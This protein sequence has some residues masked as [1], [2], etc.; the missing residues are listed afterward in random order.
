MNNRENLI[1][2]KFSDAIECIKMINN[3]LC[4]TLDFIEQ[5][6]HIFNSID[7]IIDGYINDNRIV[8]LLKDY[9][10]YVLGFKCIFYKEKL[11]DDVV[12][13]K[14]L[15]GKI[16][17]ISLYKLFVNTIPFPI[18]KDVIKQQYKDDNFFLN[19]AD[20]LKKNNLTDKEIGNIISTMIKV[21]DKKNAFE[22]SKLLAYFDIPS[23]IDEVKKHPKYC[24]HQ[25]IEFAWNSLRKLNIQFINS[26]VNYKLCAEYYIKVL[27]INEI[28]Q[29]NNENIRDNALELL[30]IGYFDEKSSEMIHFILN[31][32][33]ND[34]KTK[35]SNEQKS[36]I[37]EIMERYN[38]E[39]GISLEK[40][41]YFLTMFLSR[42]HIYDKSENIKRI[43]K[44]SIKAIIRTKLQEVGIKKCGI[45]F[46]KIDNGLLGRCNEY[47]QIPEIWINEYLISG[48]WLVAISRI[49]LLET[50]FHEMN[51][52]LVANNIK[53]K[54]I[55]F[56]TFLLL[57]DKFIDDMDYKYYDNNYDI[58]REEFD[59]NL[60]GLIET[61]RFVKSL[62][63]NPILERILDFSNKTVFWYIKD[64]HNSLLK[65]NQK[66]E[67]QLGE[68]RYSVK[69]CIL[70]RE[71]IKRNK[72]CLSDEYKILNIKYNK[73][74]SEK[75]VEQLVDDFF[76]L[77][78]KK[79]QDY[80]ISY[81]N[82]YSIF[83][84]ILK[85][86]MKNQ[87]AEVS[88]ET[89]EKLEKFFSMNMVSIQSVIQQN[90][91]NAKHLTLDKSVGRTDFT[92]ALDR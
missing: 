82:L 35:N 56:Y 49:Q 25:W 14:V 92:K 6:E 10:S 37:D 38:D 26:G 78:E 68:K 18:I 20:L 7:S 65:K 89:M 51:H 63:L 61:D 53:N 4:E 88:E 59:S 47:N 45:F 64:G 24:E 67:I 54:K 81:D 90:N 27:Q 42:K 55:D 52:V 30:R 13:N 60:N 8:S 80:E 79:I 69:K 33:E 85:A 22:V 16:N 57:E 43:L 40:A 76:N 36:I 32:S 87:K 15:S 9:C 2:R 5:N 23:T 71:M 41:K 58:Y 70:I 72:G 50:V 29:P 77:N 21:Y 31:Q 44:V 1:I 3:S 46:G 91:L 48:H 84:G 83:Y 66:V 74:G 12:F 17:N 86:K 19:Y 28:N 62:N 39:K 34:R 11:S 75:T 73:D